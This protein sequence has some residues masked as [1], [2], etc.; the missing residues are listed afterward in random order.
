MKESYAFPNKN[1]VILVLDIAGTPYEFNVSPT[2]HAFVKKVAELSREMQK[3]L[4]EFNAKK[5]E[6]LFDMEGAFDFLRDK[7]QEIVEILLPGKWE[8]L[9]KL[10]G[11]DLM[12][13]VDLITFIVSKVKQKGVEAM[14][15]QIVPEV[16]ADGAEI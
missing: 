9:F 16:P 14:K 15:E 3:L 13:M 1:Q 6:S 2:N 5:K 4:V 11:Y 12:N 10:A 8:E 7:E